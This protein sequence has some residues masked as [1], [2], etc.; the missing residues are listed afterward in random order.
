VD[1]VSLLVQ[2]P[3]ANE[4]GVEARDVVD[5]VEAAVLPVLVGEQHHPAPLNL[6]HRAVPET[7]RADD[8]A[9]ELGEGGA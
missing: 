4:V 2:L 9:V 5:S 8:A 6:D 7:H 3:D 1:V